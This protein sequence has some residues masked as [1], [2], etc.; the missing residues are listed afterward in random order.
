LAHRGVTST[1]STLAAALAVGVITPA[2]EALAGTIATAVLA[3][4]VAAGS[5]T[6][7]FLKFMSL[8]KLQAALVGALVLAG[9]AVPS[10]QQMRLQRAQSDNAQLRAHETENRTQQSELSALRDEVAR[11][12]TAEADKTEL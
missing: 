8:S 4:G 6:I 2:P 10:W 1:A 9:I 12:R 7:T 11:L 5:T 3:G